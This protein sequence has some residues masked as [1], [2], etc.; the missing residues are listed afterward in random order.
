MRIVLGLLPFLDFFAAMMVLHVIGRRRA[1]GNTSLREATLQSAAAFGLW[2]VLGTEFYSKLGILYFWPILIWWLIPLMACIAFLLRHRSEIKIDWKLRWPTIPE[3]LILLPLVALIALAFTSCVASPPNNCDS[4]AYHLP[5]QVMW[6]QQGNVRH[7]PTNDLRQLM[8]APYSEFVS[9][10]VWTLAGSDRLLNLIQ[11]SAMLIMLVGVSLATKRLGGKPLAQL[12]A[13]L[14]VVASPVVFL[15]ASN[16]KNDMVVGMWIIICGWWLLRLLDGWRLNWFDAILFGGAIG[17]AMDTK[18]TGPL[19][20]ITIVL[21][22]TIAMLWRRSWRDFGI[23]VL[24]GSVALSVNLPQWARNVKNFGHVNGPTVAEGNYPI[25][26]ET[27]APAAIISNMMRNLVWHSAVPS[28]AINDDIYAGMLWVH[29][30]LLGIGIN[31]PRITTPFSSFNKLEFHSSDEDRVGSPFH[32]LLLLLLPLALWMSRGRIDTSFALLLAGLSAAGFFVFNFAIKWEEWHVRYYIALTALICPVFA[33][34]WTARR[35]AFF[36]PIVAVLALLVI[37]P[38][39]LINPRP[40][41]GS[42]SIFVRDN[43]NKRLIYL[44]HPDEFQDVANIAANHR[45]KWVGIATDGIFPDYALMYVIRKQ[46]TPSPRFEYIQPFVRI[47]GIKPHR[48]DMII[49]RSEL[50]SVWDEPTNTRYFLYR[51]YALFNVL[52]PEGDTQTD[53]YPPFFGWTKADGLTAAMGPFPEWQL[54]LVRWGTFPETRLTIDS[55]TGGPSQLLLLMR[56]ND[57]PAQTIAVELNGT[58]LID[59]RFNGQF[60]FEPLRLSL[61]LKPGR[62]EIVFRYASGDKD[63]TI[64]RAV[65][66]RT[67]QIAPAGATATSTTATSPRSAH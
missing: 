6:M 65:L 47:K 53:Q 2:V 58:R 37:L 50:V 49:A 38:S 57:D 8:M 55:P 24:I 56:R 54:P 14:L 31:D 60:Q 29:Q 46:M 18:G 4:Y 62:N 27:H 34:A 39:V 10:Q 16:T 17:C 36:A 26:N 5:R 48:A 63:S 19:F 1:S 13:C 35:G 45:A 20:V 43:M 32:V 30:H 21:L 11:F 12:L 52:L 66:F 7:Y 51:R 40:V 33:A 67:L 3:W 23:L 41:F 42:A 25:Y 22:V 15:E 44:G 59:Y 61:A 28:Q 64:P 9:L